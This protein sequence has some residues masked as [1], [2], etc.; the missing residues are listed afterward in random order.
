MARTSTAEINIDPLLDKMSG[1]VVH[2]D[3]AVGAGDPI[4]LS[5]DE[6]G[7]STRSGEGHTLPS[8]EE[9][10]EVAKGNDTSVDSGTDT[11][12]QFRNDGL[13]ADSDRG[14]SN[15]ESD[16]EQSLLEGEQEPEDLGYSKDGLNDSNERHSFQLELEP[17]RLSMDEW[18]PAFDADDGLLR[19]EVS[20]SVLT[21]YYNWKTPVVPSLHNV[22]SNE[23]SLIAHTGNKTGL[24]VSPQR[25]QIN[26]R[27]LRKILESI[28]GTTMVDDPVIMVRP[29]KVLVSKLP[30]LKKTLA[31]KVEALDRDSTRNEHARRSIALPEQTD[32]WTSIDHL[33]VLINFIRSDLKDTLRLRQEIEDRRLEKIRF[34]DLWHLFSPGD[35]VF[36]T[37]RVEGGGRSRA[38]IVWCLG[39]GRTNLSEKPWKE[40]VGECGYAGPRNRIAGSH[41]RNDFV[42]DCFHVDFDGTLYGLIQK[43]FSIK[44]YDSEKSILNLDVYP[45]QFDPKQYELLDGLLRRGRRFRELDHI[46][47][48]TY[49]GLAPS[50]TK[51]TL[52]EVHGEVVIDF[53]T[54]YQ[55]SDAE[56]PPIGQTMSTSIAPQEEFFESSFANDRSLHDVTINYDDRRFDS[57]LAE[58]YKDRNGALFRSRNREHEDLTDEHLRLL[59]KQVLAYV[60][61]SRSWSWLNVDD[62]RDIDDD[63]ARRESGFKELVI[64]QENKNLILALVKNH[65]TGPKK[66]EIP[67]TGEPQSRQRISMD[68]VRGKGKGLIILLHGAPGV[69][70]TS[71]AETVAAYTRRPLYPITCGDV[72]ETPVEIED[73]LNWHFRLAHKWG[74]VLLLDEADVFL[75]KRERGDVRRNALVSIFLRILEYYPGILFLTT[76]RVGE[77]D[78]AFRSRI[79]LP[80]YYPNLSRAATLD[81]WD[82]CLKLLERQNE[83]RDVKIQFDREQL[84]NFAKRHFD[85]TVDYELSWNGRQIRNAFQTAIA[86]AEYDLEAR[87]KKDG[88]SDE[89][90]AAKKKYRTA[91]LTKNHFRTVSQAISGFDQYLL[92]VHKHHSQSQLAEAEELRSDG[93]TPTKDQSSNPKFERASMTMRRN[94]GGLAKARRPTEKDETRSKS[95]AKRAVAL[96]PPANPGGVTSDDE[97]DEISDDSGPEDE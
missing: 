71:T 91:N 62:V 23:T 44:P 80:L 47:H 86:L 93:W 42:L 29:F 15:Q 43:T 73:N 61:R 1:T 9:I 26:S 19:P 16:S 58:Q 88:A 6:R 97:K 4:K 84:L 2:Q 21:A 28:S 22:K 68:L 49:E 87:I 82:N 5:C 94:G 54:G 18:R 57:S 90:V 8:D 55:Y 63:E 52:V 72:G 41:W 36:A 81:M 24:A 79:H 14:Q 12:S 25:I 50:G 96:S 69:G 11:N 33:E 7:I 20:S 31:T 85:D 10:E 76:N 27:H 34:D 78:E 66:R 30:E 92:D 65:S 64:P 38:Y 83:E 77:F 59:P 60:F 45:A 67:Q 48:K 37:E 35:T 39:G 17:K 40:T 3:M 74:C 53:K 46:S 13:R 56:S 70:K 89:Q 75:A 51:E 95:E 32:L